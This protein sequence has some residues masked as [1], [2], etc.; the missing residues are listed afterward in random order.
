MNKQELV[1]S[2]CA[3]TGLTRKEAEK[4]VGAILESI[5]E[6]LSRG[7]RVSLVGFGTFEVA[8]RK[9][10]QGRDLRTGAA[11]TIPGGRVPRFRPG[12]ELR[13]TVE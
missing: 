10:R 5:R 6:E 11:I 13:D 8:E 7:G 9:E 12:R 4:A 3:R 1:G 2:V